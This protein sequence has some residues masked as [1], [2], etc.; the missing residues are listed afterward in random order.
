MAHAEKSKKIV[1]RLRD[2]TAA[3]GIEV[4]LTQLGINLCWQ[5]LYIP[6]T[7]CA[8]VSYLAP[9]SQPQKKSANSARSPHL[10]C[11][12][13]EMAEWNKVSH[14]RVASSFKAVGGSRGEEVASQKENGIDRRLSPLRLMATEASIEKAEVEVCF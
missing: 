12:H 14:S 4:V 7:V 6:S 9:K 8:V 13:L 5:S 11:R 10:L 2:S 1:P 3:F